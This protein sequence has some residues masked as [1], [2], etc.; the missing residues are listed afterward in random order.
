MC[1]FPGTRKIC[2]LRPNVEDRYAIYTLLQRK[3]TMNARYSLVRKTI[4]FL[5]VFTAFGGTAF[6]FHAIPEID[7]G[8]ASTALALVAGGLFLLTARFSRK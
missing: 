2:L 6:G 3:R 8:S 4:G 5:L 7:P 1:G